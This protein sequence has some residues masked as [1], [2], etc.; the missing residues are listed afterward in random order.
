MTDM[1]FVS[2]VPPAKE[3]PVPISAGN[4]EQKVCPHCGSTCV[5]Y[6]N[7]GKHCNQC[8]ADFDVLRAPVLG[9]KAG[10]R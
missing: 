1:T 8:S 5:I 7:I 9:A 10:F 2:L 4:C 6:L 3:Q